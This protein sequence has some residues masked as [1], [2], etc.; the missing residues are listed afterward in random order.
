[1]RNSTT[2]LGPWVRRFLLEH[3]VH[4]R[5]LA[6]NT[7]RS[8]RDTLALLAPFASDHARV[9]IDRLEVEHLSPDRVR[10]FLHAIT[11][12]RNCSPAT[13]NQRL[14]AIRAFA[15][16]V[17]RRSPEHI[18]W[19][20]HICDISFRKCAQAPVT[21]LEK[22]EIDALLA[23]PD[24]STPQGRRDHAV[25]LFL[26]NTGA[27][28]DETAQLTVGDLELGA[29]L[30]RRVFPPLF[31]GVC[32]HG[33]SLLGAQYGGT[34]FAPACCRAARAAIPACSRRLGASV[35]PSRG[36]W[37]FARRF[38][39]VPWERR[40]LCDGRSDD[41]ALGTCEAAV[42]GVLSD[43]SHGPQRRF[44]RPDAVC[45]SRGRLR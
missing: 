32:A 31:M 28:A 45:S 40:C 41:E 24:R 6:R 39:T 43:A 15:R 10:Q 4:E 9:S 20:G 16:F 1:M 34:A 23:A 18:E 12:T 25:L 5:N 14:A 29:A 2:R 27:R 35:R 42:A 26:Y 22:P 30:L 7:Q 33:R 37:T 19:S 11:V 44:L 36:P 13:C 3:L 21:Y 8:Y 17:G 38:A